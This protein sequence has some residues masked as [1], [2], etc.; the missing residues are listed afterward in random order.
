MNNFP[1]Q[2]YLFTSNNYDDF[3]DKLTIANVEQEILELGSFKATASLIFSENVMMNKFIINRKVLQKGN[4]IIGYIT[5]TIYNPNIIFNWR[6]HQM[7]KGMIGILWNRE[8][9]SIT[10]ANF[11]AYPISINEN[12]FQKSCLNKGFPD[13]IQLLKKKDLVHVSEIK[14]DKIRRLIE[15]IHKS[16]HVKDSQLSRLMEIELVD[17][18]IDCLSIALDSKPIKDMSNQ[19]F[20]NIVDFINKYIMEITS[21]SQICENNNINQRTLRRWFRNKFDLSPKQYLNFL[22]LNKIRQVLQN[23]SNHSNISE[24]AIDFNYW[25]MSQFS[26]DYKRLFNELP[27]RTWENSNIG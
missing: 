3:T 20:Y 10:G 5:F 21:V 12:Y 11:E 25:H 4:S 6:K 8:H 9:E 18:L 24:V 26:K 16:N 7:K 22:R 2:K 13:I 17:L 23:N 19:K 1:I 14:L 15:F 27:S